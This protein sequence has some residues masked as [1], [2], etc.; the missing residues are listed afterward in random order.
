MQKKC[1]VRKRNSFKFHPS[2]DSPT[3]DDNSASHFPR[4]TSSSETLRGLEFAITQI[5]PAEGEAFCSL[6]GL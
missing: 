6:L 3:K 2:F 4:F 5:V 1:G